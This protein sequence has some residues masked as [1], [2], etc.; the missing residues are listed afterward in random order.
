[1]SRFN[2]AAYDKLFPH[3]EEVEKPE[4]V[5]PT[6]TP[7][8]DKIEHPEKVEVETTVP[9]VEPEEEQTDPVEKEV[10]I[11]GNGKHSEPDPEQ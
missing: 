4:T 11:D 2:S 9:E 6:F 7:T 3:V 5:V 1:M 10:S 8:T